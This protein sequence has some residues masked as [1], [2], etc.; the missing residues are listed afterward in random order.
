MGHRY[1]GGRTAA[2]VLG[3]GLVGAQIVAQLVGMGRL[4]RAESGDGHAGAPT[5]TV[6]VDASQVLAKTNPLL[7][8]INTAH[9]DQTIFPGTAPEALLTANREVVRKVRESGVTI[10]KYPG[11]TAADYYVW[12]DPRNPAADMDT[13]EL[14]LLAR[15]VGAEP[16]IQVNIPAGPEVAAAWVEYTNNIHHYNVKYWELGDEEYGSWARGHSSPEVYAARV[17]Q[18][19]QAMKA[20]D[21]TI[22]IGMSVVGFSGYQDWTR[23]V[24]RLAGDVIDMV[25]FS[26]YPLEPGQESPQAFVQAADKLQPQLDYIHRILREEQPSRADDILVM[27]GGWNT[28]SANPSPLV[29]AMPNALFVARMLAEMQTLDVDGANYWAVHNPPGPRGGEYGYLKAGTHEPTYP[30][31]VFKLF[32]D[33]WGDTVVAAESDRSW[34]KAYASL[35]KDALGTTL[36]TI[37][38]NISSGRTETVQLVTEGFEAGRYSAWIL[39]EGKKGEEWP[40]SEDGRVV[41]PPFSMVV[42]KAAQKPR[43]GDYVRVFPIGQQ[44]SS[45]LAGFEAAQVTDRDPNTRWSSVMGAGIDPQWLTL[46]FGFPVRIAKVVIRWEAAYATRYEVQLSGDGQTWHTVAKVEA[47]DG[48]TDEL[49][50][51]AEEARQLRLLLE[52]R[53][54]R[55][56]GYSIWETEVY[57]QW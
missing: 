22:K 37:L 26:F 33:H 45:E 19:V 1:R 23:R 27:I 34:I 56:F 3:W 43:A 24:V 17:R 7:F 6:R 57:S 28:V 48:G 41:L 21:P 38:L 9:W 20:K 46:D 18:F 55:R 49:V 15:A 29:E 32:A 52:E 31:Y 44:A 35:K 10:L 25:V 8:G 39:A 16:W 2:V 50:F 11:G 53:A 47:G 14:V 40:V 12:N 4:A 30:W 54:D 51:P 13:D 5:V 42:V 36:T